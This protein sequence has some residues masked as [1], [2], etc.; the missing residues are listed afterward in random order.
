MSDISVSDLTA[1][2]GVNDPLYTWWNSAPALPSGVTFGQFLAHTLEA[3]NTAQSNVNVNLVSP[4]KVSG[5][6]APVYGAISKNSD[7]T[8]TIPFSAAF[9]GKKI[10]TLI[11][12]PT[13]PNNV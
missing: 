9:S 4:N 8:A 2:L 10:V 1:A 6:G 13:S 3:A 5:Y 11:S 12:A 7:G